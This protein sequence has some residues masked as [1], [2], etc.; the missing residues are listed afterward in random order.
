MGGRIS[1]AE[2]EEIVENGELDPDL[3][4]TPGIF[5]DRIFKGEKFEGKYEKLVYDQDLYA[6]RIQYPAS[7]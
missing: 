6:I 3:I 7:K 2:V 4:H 5:V 1:V